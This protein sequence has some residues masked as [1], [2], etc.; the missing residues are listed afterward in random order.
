VSLCLWPVGCGV[1]PDLNC[2]SKRETGGMCIQ[3]AGVS[4]STSALLTGRDKRSQVHHPTRSNKRDH[5]H[6]TMLTR[7]PEGIKMCPAQR[8]SRVVSRNPNR[9]LPRSLQTLCLS[10]YLFHFLDDTHMT[11]SVHPTW[12][13]M[14]RTTTLLEARN[15]TAAIA[16]CQDEEVFGELCRLVMGDEGHSAH[17]LR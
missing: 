5:A 7:N 6:V 14:P 13:H 17:A 4:H 10:P 2:Q 3:Y 1:R 15:R 8:T 12:R 9:R 16:Q 11:S